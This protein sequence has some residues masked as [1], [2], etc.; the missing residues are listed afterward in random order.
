MADHA[1]SDEK[2]VQYEVETAGEGLN[3]LESREHCKRAKRGERE[4]DGENAEKWGRAY[5]RPSAGEV[6]GT[7]KRQVG[8][9]RFMRSIKK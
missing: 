4:R 1:E 9:R 2:K 5:E 7:N 3:G 6:G 8:G